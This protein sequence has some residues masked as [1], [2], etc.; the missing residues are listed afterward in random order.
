MEEKLQNSFE[1]SMFGVRWNGVT[2]CGSIFV[3]LK[4]GYPKGFE[5]EMFEF[6]IHFPWQVS[7]F[8]TGWMF[9]YMVQ[10]IYKTLSES[11]I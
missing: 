6:N 8:H 5:N 2:V 4:R 7:H 1:G 3:P 10:Y 11:D 9:F